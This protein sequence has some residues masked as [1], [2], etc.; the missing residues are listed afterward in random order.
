MSMP[1]FPVVDGDR[2]P[3]NGAPS[4]ASSADAAGGAGG[5][6]GVPKGTYAEPPCEDGSEQATITAPSGVTG[7][8][9]T[10]QCYSDSTCPPPGR[11]LLRERSWLSVF[12]GR[13][14]C[15]VPCHGDDACPAGA[16][17]GMM[18]ER[19]GL[20]IF[21]SGA[22]TQAVL[23]RA[24]AGARAGQAAAGQGLVNV[25]PGRRLS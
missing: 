13:K 9:C 18:T 19:G 14:Y 7:G 21:A 1:S 16:I 3:A 5:A 20:C 4:P 15:A 8:M 17:C 25:P 6:G 2:A 22:A 10:F 23:A 12:F 24:G 11:C